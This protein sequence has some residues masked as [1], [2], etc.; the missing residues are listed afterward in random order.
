MKVLKAFNAPHKFTFVDPDTGLVYSASSRKE[1]LTNIVRYRVQNQLEP[2]PQLEATVVNYWCTLPENSG[3][4]EDGPEIDRTFYQYIKGG[5]AL[6]KSYLFDSYVAQDEADRRSVLC[7]SCPNNIFPDKKG[8]LA[9]SD[10]QAERSI[11]ERRS[12]HHNDLGNCSV[13]SCLLKS[14][15]WFGGNIS[16]PLD[17]INQIKKTKPD[18]WQLPEKATKK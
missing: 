4:C 12:V 17:Q 11:G 1:L 14:K 3:K 13:C 10:D 8:F 7:V 2:I 15:V 18:C 5:V 9:W 16:L 6:L